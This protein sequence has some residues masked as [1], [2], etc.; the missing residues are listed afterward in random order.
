VIDDNAYPREF[1]DLRASLKEFFAEGLE[2]RSSLR[3]HRAPRFTKFAVARETVPF[4]K[5]P[6]PDFERFQR[7]GLDETA[8]G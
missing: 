5:D 3:A 2:Y 6:H 7:T 8:G 4:G 1:D